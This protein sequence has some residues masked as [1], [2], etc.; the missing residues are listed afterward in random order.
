[1]FP[2]ASVQFSVFLC[3]HFRDWQNVLL[4]RTGQGDADGHR[5]APDL[6]MVGLI[7][8]KGLFQLRQLYDSIEVPW[9]LLPNLA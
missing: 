6:A 5:L 1:M 4:A 7:D 8:L 2:E 3:W 9:G